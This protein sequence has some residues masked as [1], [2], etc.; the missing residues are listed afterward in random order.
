VRGHTCATT[1]SFD[2]TPLRRLAYEQ[3]ELV[4]LYRAFL[5]DPE[6]HLETARLPP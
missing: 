5:A 1:W 2:E 3:T 6:A 4:R